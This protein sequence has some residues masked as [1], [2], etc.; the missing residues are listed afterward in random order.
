MKTGKRCIVN[1]QDA[2]I[3]DVL[4]GYGF[5]CIPVITSDKVSRPISAHSDVLYRKIGVNTIIISSCQKANEQLLRDYGYDVIIYDGMRPGYRKECA[6]NFILTDDYLIYNPGTAMDPEMLNL[7]PGI[8]RI[9]VKQGYTGCSVS[10]IGKAA[11]ITSDPG[12]Y[13]RLRER[14]IDCYFF[15]NYEIS[16]EGYDRGFIGGSSC[17]ISDDMLLIFGQIRD[18]SVREGLEG[19][20]SSH[21]VRVEYIRDKTVTDIGSALI[22]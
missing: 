18:E 9:Q 5:E 6:L 14:Q 7:G 2:Q 11:F 8:T 13:S 19:F 12:I 3:N 22:L 1:T 16:L 10:A 17:M 15:D 20:C 21:G 4:R